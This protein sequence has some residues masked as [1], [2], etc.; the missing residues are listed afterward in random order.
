MLN[1]NKQSLLTYVEPV[2][3]DHPRILEIWVI[4]IGVFYI[5]DF[6]GLNFKLINF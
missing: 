2:Y 5:V 3:K 6:L 1:F 4:N